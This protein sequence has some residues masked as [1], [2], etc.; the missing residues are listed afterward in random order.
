MG[1]RGP[2]HTFATYPDELQSAIDQKIRKGVTYENIVSWINSM[3]EVK[4]GELKGT[5]T[6]GVSRYAKNFK[7]RLE[8]SKRLREQVKAVI[9]ESKDSPDTDMVDAANKFAIELLVERVMDANISELQEENI[10]EVMK[11]AT[12]LQ[13][14][15]VST[16]RL[17]INFK[18]YQSDIENKRKKA[19]SEFT[20]RLYDELEATHPELYE[21]LVIIANETFEKIQ[22]ETQ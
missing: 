20:K 8:H 17:K 5:S 4:N 1:D 14:S 21:K 3:E 16:E 7:E 18:K 11:T 15:Q 19:F 10:L 12:N 2:Q 9:D 6:A 13:R 22:L